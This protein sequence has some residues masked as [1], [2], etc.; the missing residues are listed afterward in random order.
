MPI[1][2]EDLDSVHRLYAALLARDVPALMKA[3]ANATY[4]VPG[5][6]IVAGSYRG[7]EEILGLFAKTQQETNDTISFELHDLVGGEN[8]IVMLDHVKAERNGRTLDQ[9]R[10]VISHVENGIT[11]D[12]WLV[13]EDEYDFDEFWS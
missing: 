10:V 6:N 2:E 3:F 11:T 1:S 8:H 9:S 5:N 13:V 12:V 7:S 4:H